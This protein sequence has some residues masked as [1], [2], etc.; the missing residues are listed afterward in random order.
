MELV[1]SK[2]PKSVKQLNFADIFAGQTC[3]FGNNDVT[4][5]PHHVGMKIDSEHYISLYSNST[6]LGRKMRCIDTGSP[7]SDVRLVD[8][9]IIRQTTKPSK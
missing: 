4:E 7:I 8:Q 1:I 5:Y 9:F 2:L 3:V 6:Y